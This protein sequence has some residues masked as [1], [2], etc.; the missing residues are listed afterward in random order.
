ME[1]TK[2]EDLDEQQN[3][4]VARASAIVGALHFEATRIAR[5]ARRTDGF[6]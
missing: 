2:F 4:D 3:Q 6:G 5:A 1:A